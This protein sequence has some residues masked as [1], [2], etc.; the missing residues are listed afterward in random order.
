MRLGVL[1]V[2]CFVAAPAMAGPVTYTF[3]VTYGNLAIAL[4]GQ[5]STYG[6]LGGTFAATIYQSDCH[7]G[8]SDTLIMEDALLSNIDPIALGIAG[9]ATA[10]VHINSARF[11]DFLPDGP[12][13]IGPGGVTMV[14]T[15]V[16]VEVTAIV[17]GSFKTTFITTT[18]AGILLPFQLIVGTSAMR[19]DIL[20]ADLGFT[21][22]WVIGI[23]D[24]GLTITLDLIVQ[25]EGT[26]HV[27][28]DPALGGFTAMGL[29]GAGAWLRRRR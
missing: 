22:G 23:S 5:G 25:A 12:D 26:A 9:I 6:G 3:D 16:I 20:I 7:I 18:S 4:L 11:V 10:N 28:P 24:I 2:L 27:V 1:G 13:H 14:D 15:D 21:Y 29:A 17:T 19:S 8:E